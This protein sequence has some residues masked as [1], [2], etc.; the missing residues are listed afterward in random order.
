MERI[1][2][3]L[4][5]TARSPTSSRSRGSAPTEVPIAKSPPIVKIRSDLTRIIG[6]RYLKGLQ[7][8]QS[9]DRDRA[10][11]GGRNQGG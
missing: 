6:N 3:F 7:K 5:I 9:I 4:K 10:S 11:S 8:T 1:V 2:K